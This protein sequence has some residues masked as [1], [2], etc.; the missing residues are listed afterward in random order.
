MVEYIE[1]VL[2]FVIQMNTTQY[3]T[4]VIAVLQIDAI[5]RHQ[6]S[7]QIIVSITF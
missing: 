3:R 1:D 6:Y 2:L 4:Q 7:I 5:Q